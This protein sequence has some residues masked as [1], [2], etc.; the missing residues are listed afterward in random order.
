MHTINTVFELVANYLSNEDLV[1]LLSMEEFSS[2]YKLLNN[3]YKIDNGVVSFSNH[4]LR[5]VTEENTCVTNFKFLPEIFTLNLINGMCKLSLF[6]NLQELN[7]QYV[8]YDNK[9]DISTLK[10]LNKISIIDCELD[11]SFLLQAKFNSLKQLEIIKTITD[12]EEFIVNFNPRNFPELKN[13][14]F[15]NTGIDSLRKLKILCS[16]LNFLGNFKYLNLSQNDFS[17]AT[18]CTLFSYFYGFNDLH[19]L[20]LSNCKLTC[21]SVE[22]IAAVFYKSN[23]L[24]VLHLND[25]PDLLCCDDKY[26][27]F[28]E[29]MSLVSLE[30]LDISNVEIPPD[31]IFIM[32]SIQSKT[33]KKL[34]MCNC[35]IKSI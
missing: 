18:E 13:V 2:H 10:K 8:K 28:I 20:K 23:S 9:I 4:T 14:S 12:F 5:L 27:N 3:W 6:T 7:L 17:E 22:N 16:I 33:L 19:T 32:C 24:K 11:T 35:H 1:Q 26:L 29:F 25:N 31:L 15:I 21:S 30:E 34:K